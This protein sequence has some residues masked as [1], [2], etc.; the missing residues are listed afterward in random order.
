MGH[1]ASTF[2]SLV[3][4]CLLPAGAAVA[5]GTGQQASP[6]LTSPFSPD[7]AKP[8]PTTGGYIYIDP[9]Q[10]QIPAQANRPRPRPEVAGAPRR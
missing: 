10:R 6:P 5:Q 2:A 1:V 8:Y 4:L 3:G 9:R 7:W